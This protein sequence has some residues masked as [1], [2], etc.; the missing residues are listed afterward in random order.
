MS[1]V[2]NLSFLF[3][4]GSVTWLDLI[5]LPVPGEAIIVCSLIPFCHNMTFILSFIVSQKITVTPLACSVATA[6][7]GLQRISAGPSSL[8]F[9]MGPV[10][11]QLF[12]GVGLARLT[13]IFLRLC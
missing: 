10:R 5:E 9:Q 1:E 2:I 6:L 4:T 8:P 13:V 12:A 11:P 3:L 7:I